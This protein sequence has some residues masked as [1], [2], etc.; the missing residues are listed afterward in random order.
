MD[1]AKLDASWRED[2]PMYVPLGGGEY[3][4]RWLLA[5]ARAGA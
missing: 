1:T 5:H 3:F 2:A 4:G